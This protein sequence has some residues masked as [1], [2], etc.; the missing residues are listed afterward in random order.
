M[1]I[2]AKTLLRTNEVPRWGLERRPQ[3]EGPEGALKNCELWHQ[4][5]THQTHRLRWKLKS[6]AQ[7]AELW[8]AK[9][10]DLKWSFS[11][12]IFWSPTPRWKQPLK[13]EWDEASIS[14]HLRVLNTT[15]SHS[16]CKIQLTIGWEAR[17]WERKEWNDCAA[18]ATL[19]RITT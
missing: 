18:K 1:L 15:V 17:F 6:I 2:Q 11:R 7:P 9:T 3:E 5:G 8:G 14:R 4:K 19:Q 10:R 12:Q 13:A 16:S